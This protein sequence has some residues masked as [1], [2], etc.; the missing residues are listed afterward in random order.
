MLSFVMREKRDVIQYYSNYN[1]SAWLNTEKIQVVSSIIGNDTYYGLTR[2][3]H[4]RGTRHCI[5][6]YKYDR[7]HGIDIGFEY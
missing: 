4:S 7:F 3:F 5:I 6:T 2:W 1:G